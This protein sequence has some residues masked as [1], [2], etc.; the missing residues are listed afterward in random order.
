MW[1]ATL[2]MELLIP[3]VTEFLVLFSGWVGW[4]N[5][6]RNGPIEIIF[7][8]DSVRDFTSLSIFANNQFTKDVQVGYRRFI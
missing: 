1:K 5:E 4:K 8:F 7:E 3:V 2:E 6:G